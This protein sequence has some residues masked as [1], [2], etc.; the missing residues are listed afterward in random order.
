MMS[1][2]LL[3]ISWLFLV[4]GAFFFIAGTVGLLRFPDVYARLHAVTKADTLGLGFI[5]V[6][7]SLR[8][9]SWQAISIM[10]LI[11][12]LVMASGTTACQLLAQYARTQDG[13]KS[14]RAAPAV[15]SDMPANQEAN[16]GTD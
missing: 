10:V 1:E 11:W 16:D 5:V 8:A 2:W 6:G 4:G 13:D 14:Y 3:T 7:L 15:K 12:L 9:E